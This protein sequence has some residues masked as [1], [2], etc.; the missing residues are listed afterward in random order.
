[1][2]RKYRTSDD[3]IGSYVANIASVRQLGR[4]APLSS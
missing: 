3:A 2:H 4:A 1:M